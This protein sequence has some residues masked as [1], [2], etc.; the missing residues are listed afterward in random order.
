MQMPTQTHTL[1]LYVCEQA[2]H[3]KTGKTS[4]LCLALDIMTCVSMR[5]K[6]SNLPSLDKLSYSDPMAC[7][8][9]TNPLGGT[10]GDGNGDGDGGKGD[11]GGQVN[12]AGGGKSSGAAEET[13]M[14]VGQTERLQNNPHPEF[15]TIIDASL[16][17]NFNAQVDA[18]CS[19]VFV[20]T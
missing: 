16:I 14:F 2:V 19:R 6:C 5:L 7:I 10:N 9:V 15:K 20:C 13:W 8:F 1:A 17:P 12:G 3:N 11:D 4:Y 18:K